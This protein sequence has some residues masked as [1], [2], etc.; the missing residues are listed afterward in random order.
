MAYELTWSPTARLD[1]IDI[2]D[3]IAKDNNLAAARFVKNLFSEIERL[4]TF[5]ES[6]RVV[7]EFNDPAVREIIKKP[8]RIVYRINKDKS[9]IEIV[10][11]W[12]AARGIP[13]IK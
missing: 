3:F 11:V 1:L 2:A 5:P 12:H 7:P 8:C 6:G 13:D 10:R 4:A 9:R